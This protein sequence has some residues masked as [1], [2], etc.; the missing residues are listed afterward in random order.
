MKPKRSIFRT[1]GATLALAALISL[2][3]P[4]SASADSSANATVI[5]VATVAYKDV[6]GTTSFSATAST[7]T[8]VNLVKAALNTSAPPTGA[9]G[10]PALACLAAGSYASGSTISSLYALT[11]AA[12][13]SNS[14]NLS[15]AQGTLTNASNV[16]VTYSTRTYTGTLESAAPG[17]RVFGSAIPTGIKDASTLYFPGGSLSGF[18]VNDIVLV[19]IAGTKK[20]FLVANVV[21]GSAASHT[22]GG[23]VA[24]TSVGTTT[25]EVKGELTLAA[26]AN[27]TI[28]GQTVGGGGVAPAFLTAGSI[29]TLGVPIGEMALVQIDVT[30]TVTSASADAT[31]QYTLTATDSTN[32]ATVTCTAGN[33]KAT[34]LSIKKE[35]RNFTQGGL[36]GASAGGNPGEV[37]E[38]RVTVANVGGQAASVVVSD[39][40]PVY[41][42]LMTYTGSYG[43]GAAGTIFAQISNGINPIDLTLTAA[44]SETQPVAPSAKVGFGNS[45]GSV[46]GSAITFNVGHNSTSALGGVVPACSDATKATQALCVGPATWITSYT[47]LYR[48][49]ID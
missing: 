40:V 34:A 43:A 14:Y 13:G 2:G 41:T 36:F 6:T 15:I 27:Q 10:S 45:A 33:Y 46:A 1:I 35:V 22:N 42:T 3:S 20:A 29:P 39:A 11:A 18:A 25:A 37:L 16:T 5:N 38:Y 23:N 4:G 9:N 44:D 12:N 47:I 17:A 28:L 30:A 7:T 49:K 24:Q 32:S 31:V 8:T 26:Y 48:V 21:V 19:D